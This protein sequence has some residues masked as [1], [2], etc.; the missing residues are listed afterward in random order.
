V[1]AAVIKGP[2]VIGIEEVAKPS[3][4]AGEILLKVEMSAL[5]GTDQR[6]LSGDKNADV[7]IIGHE[8]SGI[9]EELGAG[10]TGYKPGERHA[11]VTVIGC[12]H[13]PMCEQ[14]RE[15]LCENTFKAIGYA[16]D[17]GF[18]EYMIMPAQGVKQGCLV[19]LPD[20]MSAALGTMLE[21]LSCCVSGLRY[22]PLNQARQVVVIG[23]GIIGV[24][25]GLVAKAMGAKE[26]ILMNRSGNRLELMK[27]LGIPFDHF[28]DMSQHNP[29]EWVKNH[30]RGRGVDAVIISASD[31]SLVSPS[32]RMLCRGGHLSLFA[33]FNKNEPIE[34]IDVNRIHYLELN[35]HGANSSVYQDYIEARDLLLSGKVNGDSLITHKFKLDD[36]NQAMQVQK[37]RNSGSLKILIEP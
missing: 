37:D 13:C 20:T 26:I 31:K 1:K 24:M 6:V 36:F 32:L 5:C 12:G 19:P 10:V 17:G 28:V 4:K 8:I 30:T 3:P 11:I 14:H 29:E 2:G 27:K 23:A 7:K 18:A 35:V 9:I 16:F 34:P 21:P 15:N 33:G 22:L 25:N